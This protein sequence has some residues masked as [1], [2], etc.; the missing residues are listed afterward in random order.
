MND[1]PFRQPHLTRR[2]T[3]PQ[4]NAMA[5]GLGTCNLAMRLPSYTHASPA[6]IAFADRLLNGIA[7]NIPISS[8]PH[9]AGDWLLWYG[10]DL[11]GY[12]EDT[13]VVPFPR[14]RV[15]RHLPRK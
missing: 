2:M 5:I 11:L 15:R 8:V 1:D 14:H 12:P 13:V 3:M 6:D 4:R 7:D 9:K 10:Y